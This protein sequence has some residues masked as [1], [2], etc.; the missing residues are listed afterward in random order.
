MFLSEER[1]PQTPEANKLY[2]LVDV[3][4]QKITTIQTTLTE[5]KEEKDQVSIIIKKH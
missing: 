2:H 5:L 1:S 4:S 3:K